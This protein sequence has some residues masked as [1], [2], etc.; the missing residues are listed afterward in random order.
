MPKTL[1]LITNHFPFGSPESFIGGEYPFL[2]SSFG[3]VFILS[4]NV[5]AKES[6]KGNFNCYRVNPT[7]SL[8]EI[9]FAIPLFLKCLSTAVSLIGSE[10][11]FLNKSNRLNIN[12]LRVLFHDISKAIITSSHISKI[13]ELNNI[14]GDVVLYSYWLTSSA[15]STFFVDSDRCAIKRISRAHG[16]DIYEERHSGRYLSFRNALANKLDAIFCISLNGIEYLKTRIEIRNHHKLK[17][18]RLGTPDNDIAYHNR[19]QKKI[20]VSCSFLVPV[21]RIDFLIDSLAMITDEIQW[22]H[23][24]DGSL[25]NEIRVQADNKLSQSRN[26]SFQFKGILSSTEMITFY[27]STPIYLFV[28]TSTSEGIPVA[29]ME[30]QSFGIPILG[31]NVGGVSEIVNSSNG[32]LLAAN[33]TPKEYSEA[34]THLLH[35][36]EADLK[37]MREQA[38]QNWYKFYNAVK[39]FST[40][41]DQISSLH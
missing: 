15:L 22:I 9:I 27:K 23:V 40:F 21:K 41:A 25:M 28:N 5:A 10:I 30:A 16:G 3:K 34:L 35:L 24:G 31:L 19:S 1:I 39:N 6:R 38:R 17:L 37:I 29:M 14:S 26:I 11:S 32:M 4:R 18:A 20:I 7:S 8:S 2:E 36:P 12:N 33:S 13:I